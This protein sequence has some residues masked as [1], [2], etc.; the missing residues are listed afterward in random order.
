M[1]LDGERE[2][3]R[4]HLC[5]LRMRCFYKRRYSLSLYHPFGC[6]TYYG[7][8]RLRFDPFSITI[9]TGFG[10]SPAFESNSQSPAV[11][12]FMFACVSTYIYTAGRYILIEFGSAI[13]SM[14]K[15]S[16]YSPLSIHSTL[17]RLMRAYIEAVVICLLLFTFFS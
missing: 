2:R 5:T 17:C 1:K 7:Y 15:T 14:K 16:F 8:S 9:A 3:E 13:S 11:S 10:P 6:Y 4:C 12:L